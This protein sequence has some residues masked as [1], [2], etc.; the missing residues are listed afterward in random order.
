MKI[1]ADNEVH[2]WHANPSNFTDIDSINYFTDLLTSEE[3]NR[4][5]KFYFSDHQHHYLV[6][7]ALIRIVLSKYISHIRPE[8]WRFSANAYGK[9]YISNN[10]LQDALTFNVSHTHGAIVLALVKNTEVGIDI[11]NKNRKTNINSIYQNAF[12]NDEI[13]ML[14]NT[15]LNMKNELFFKLWT[16]K[17]A[18]VKARGLGLSL[19]FNQFSF[20]FPSNGRIFISFNV[21]IDDQPDNWQFVEYAISPEYCLSLAVRLTQCHRFYNISFIPFTSGHRETSS[22]PFIFEKFSLLTH[23]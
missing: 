11:E 18:Y 9:P 17:E 14:D 10:R 13:L 6:T 16:L 7:R 3:L 2:V 12:S 4:K 22:F 19:S 23:V 1:L 21:L 15:P 8:E 5:N 20:S